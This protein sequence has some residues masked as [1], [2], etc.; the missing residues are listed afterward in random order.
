MPDLT[1]CIWILSMRL[2]IL[3]GEY[4]EFGEI[5]QKIKLLPNI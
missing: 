1:V 5:F 2:S 4:R 3:K